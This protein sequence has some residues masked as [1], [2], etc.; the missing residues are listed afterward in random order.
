MPLTKSRLRLTIVPSALS[1]SL[2]WY[3]PGAL[4]EGGFPE[5]GF[6]QQSQSDAA[7]SYST[8]GEAVS[9]GS[10][11]IAASGPGYS[12]TSTTGGVSAAVNLSTAAAVWDTTTVQTS[13][14]S[15]VIVDSSSASVSFTK[16]GASLVAGKSMTEATIMIN[17]KPYVVAQEL[18]IAFARATQF[19]SSSAVEVEGTL[20]LAGSG[21]SSAPV[22]ASKGSSR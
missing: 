22:A 20:T 7:A 10:V 14:P 15:S 12:L 17:G 13:V 3:M 21:Y 9:A 16:G 4:A 6:V 1:L 5:P 19:G 11:T 2:L 18:A 8:R